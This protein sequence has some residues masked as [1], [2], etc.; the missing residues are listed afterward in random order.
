MWSKK[1]SVKLEVLK[2]GK[3]YFK[4]HNVDLMSEPNAILEINGN[5]GIIKAIYI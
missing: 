1:V 3:Y 2:C 5:K 4:M